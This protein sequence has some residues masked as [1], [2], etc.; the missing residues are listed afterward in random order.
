MAS[1]VLIL[2][3]AFMLA[4]N[5]PNVTP[6]SF[7]G[8]W[9]GT[10]TWAIDSASPSA[11]E[12]QPVELNIQLVDGKLTGFMNPWFGGSDGATFTETTIAGEELKATA[13]VG[14]PPAAGARGQRGNW[15][16][17]VQIQFKFKSEAKESLTGTAD[18][19]LD[20]VKW[21]K[22]NYNL[23]KKRSRY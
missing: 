23:S 4:Q 8:I 7:A 9:V 11:K 1:S 12:E 10:Q 13:V 17:S 3:Y 19:T 22:F 16:S 2:L 20:G 6:S 14:K 5:A 18:V 15:K 21:L